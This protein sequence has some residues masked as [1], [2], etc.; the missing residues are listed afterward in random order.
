MLLIDPNFSRNLYPHY[1]LLGSDWYESFLHFVPSADFLKVTRNALPLSWSIRSRGVW[2]HASPPERNMLEQGW[3]IHISATRENCEQILERCTEICIRHEVAFKFL[4]D[5]FVF[6]TIMNKGGARESGGKFI[7]V[8]PSNVDHFRLIADDLRAALAEFKGPYILS[9]KRYKDSEVVHYRYGA[10]LGYPTLSAY[11]HTAT[12]LQDPNGTRVQDGRS[13]FFDPPSWID[14]PFESRVLDANEIDVSADTTLYLKNGKYRI[15]TPIQFS[16]TG[17]V[18]RAV[19]MDTGRTVIIKEA[20]PYTDIDDDGKDAVWR[21]KKEY[22]LLEKLSGTG[23]T[24]EPLDLFEDWEHLFLVEEFLEGD[25]LYTLMATWERD[26]PEAQTKDQMIYVEGLHKLWTKFAYAF[27]VFHERNIVIN[28]VSPGNVIIS[29]NDDRTHLID[30]EGAWEVGVDTPYTV[31]GTRGYRPLDGVHGPSDD[32]YGLG[33][34][35]LSMLFPGN[36]LLN[37]K[38][39]AKQIYLD[40]AEK[41]GNLPTGM[42]TLVSDCLDSDVNVR[43]SA[44]EILDRLDKVS[45]ETEHQLSTDD[46]AISDALLTDTVDKMLTYIKSTVSFNR[47]DRLFPADPAV[48]LTNPLS[49]AHGASGVAYALWNLEGEVPDQVVA[50]MLEREISNEKYTPGLY[51]GLSGIAWVYWKLGQHEL[52]LQL[53]KSAV[54]HP[55]LSELPDLYYGT[56]G[57]GLASLFFHKETEDPYWLEQAIKAGDWLI[58]TKTASK[59]GYYW[60]DPEGHVWCGYARGQSGIALYFLYLGIVTG[61]SRFQDAGRTALAY[62][63]AQ[64]ENTRNGLKI[65]RA[66][67]DS[68]STL[69]QNVA[70]HY[71]SDGSAGVCTSL[72]RYWHVFGDDVYKN[73]L[74]ELL[75]DTS[76]DLTAFPTL[77]TGLAGLG[78]LQLDVFDFT[79]DPKYISEALRITEGILRFQLDKPD[80]IAFPGEQ[81]LRISTDFGSGSA[82]IALFLSRLANREKRFQNFNFL[83]DDL[84]CPKK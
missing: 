37:L 79:N 20:R 45:V 61:E 82:G 50:W 24:P 40:L 38:P 62:D 66:S 67:G 78:N 60:P 44:D 4:S 12:L 39:E 71:W 9:D 58:N 21:L 22:R 26:T 48:F 77:F 27:K 68:V 81:L 13:A 80:G 34:V 6:N 49:V 1:A 15:E 25:N 14:D 18:Y 3:K 63:L 83:L 59:D 30:L 19:D 53:M 35:M 70:S 17:G 41:S 55:L 84:L 56:A 64:M 76:R 65:P 5:P 11:G 31:F 16:L 46:I 51:L 29:Q 8:Y 33:R 74:E 57:F 42:K 47:D 54:K 7:T 36:M 69:H 28:D 75:P 52:A 43:P 10:F 72:L 23:I 32:I 73:T 2:I